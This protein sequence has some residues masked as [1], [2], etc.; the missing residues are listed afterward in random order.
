MAGM[1]SLQE[2]K[3]EYKA[4]QILQMNE[5]GEG[6]RL[7]YDVIEEIFNDVRNCPVAIIST[8]GSFRKGKSFIL[9]L[10]TQYLLSNQSNSSFEK[11]V[12][13][14]DTFKWRGGVKRNTVGIHITNKPFMLTNADGEKVAVFL[15]D[16]QGTFDTQTSAKDCSI[17]FAMSTILSSV[18]I[19]NLSGQILETDLQHLQIFTNY[20]KY[21]VEKK[22]H[23]ADSATHFQGIMFMIRNWENVDF[24]SGFGGGA[25]YLKTV[26][27]VQVAENKSTRQNLR[28]SFSDVSCT[29]FPHPG[30]RVSRRKAE[31]INKLKF[32]DIDE[33]FLKE[34]KALAKRLFAKE[35]LI[36][37]KLGGSVVTGDQL[38]ALAIECT[39]IFSSGNMPKVGTMVETNEKVAFLGKIKQLEEEYKINMEKK[40]GDDYIDAILLEELHKECRAQALKEYDTYDIFDNK[41]ESSA[42]RAEMDKNITLAF[43][44]IR[45]NNDTRK[46][47]W[48]LFIREQAVSASY[49]YKQ[50]LDKYASGKY[51]NSMGE[52]VEKATSKACLEFQILTRKCDK[53]LEVQC[54]EAF[55]AEVELKHKEFEEENNT[56]GA[57]EERELN[58]LATALLKKYS[59]KMTKATECYAENLN[60]IHNDL[61]TRVFH[62]FDKSTLLK[63]TQLRLNIRDELLTRIKQ[64]FCA[65]QRRNQKTE[66]DEVSKIV[67]RGIEDYRAKLQNLTPDRYMNEAVIKKA[68]AEATKAALVVIEELSSDKG[69][70]VTKSS[71]DKIMIFAECES[72]SMLTTNESMKAQIVNRFFTK[73][74][75]LGKRYFQ[76]NFSVMQHQYV[77]E[78]DLDAKHIKAKENAVKIY[79]SH[80]SPPDKEFK[81]HQAGLGDDIEGHYARVKANNLRNKE[82]LMSKLQQFY[83]ILATDYFDKMCEVTRRP[84]ATAETVTQVHEKFTEMLVEE[85]TTLIKFNDILSTCIEEAQGVLNDKFEDLKRERRSLWNEDG[86]SASNIKSFGLLGAIKWELSRFV[87]TENVGARLRL[88]VTDLKSLAYLK[89]LGMNETKCK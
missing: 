43:L 44:R 35:N 60:S 32:A 27:E 52:A 7:K 49:V 36:T 10:L 86:S 88:K 20:A 48:V 63:E 57:I 89:K 66:Q 46:G 81:E 12:C 9:S 45:S 82:S 1:E 54:D 15:M 3:E 84:Y 34:V 78:R 16:T 79:R 71:I 25:K 41:E 80:I 42:N 83:K 18:Q 85:I 22:G 24:E 56:R 68:H 53:R 50:E 75:S 59:S 62:M 38:T 28:K 72:Q 69:E 77:S 47:S 29:L 51:L 37:K 19:Y 55:V 4:V 26:M 5:K 65:F 73:R 30:K 64:H 61:V 70:A 13:V 58:L 17:I 31:E 8:A 74:V 67:E 2:S 39:K 23:E 33:D 14:M 21:A 76:D 87:G 40:V 6:F 11:D